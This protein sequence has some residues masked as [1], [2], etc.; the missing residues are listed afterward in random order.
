MSIA[1][2]VVISN[3]AL[4]VSNAAFAQG[5]LTPANS[6]VANQGTFEQQEACKPDVF[7]LCGNAIPDVNRIVACLVASEPNLSP[8]CHAVFFPSADAD[9]AKRRAGSTS[10]TTPR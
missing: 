10:R 2:L 6:T 8:S 4:V 3:V 5:S 7:R 9:K 1:G